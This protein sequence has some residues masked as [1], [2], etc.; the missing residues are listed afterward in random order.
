MGGEY[1]MLKMI[2]VTDPLTE[3]NCYILTEEKHCVVIDPGEAVRTP[4]T[5][6]KSG[7]KPELI[8]LTHEHCDHMGGLAE[9]RHS[10]PE[11][12]FLATERCDCGI[13]SIKLNM[14]GIMGAY[15]YFRGKPGIH[16][17][18]FVCDAADEIIP[19]DAVL[20]WRGHTLRLIPLPGHSPGSSGIMLDEEILFSGDYLLPGEEVILR[21]PGGDEEVYRRETEPV[22]K[23]L[24]KGITICP[25]HGDRYVL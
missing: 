13:R 9:L 11:A 12:R 6:M 20:Q 4:E 22:L 23:R 24:P 25:G 15:L 2:T 7:L 3:S 1:C 18:S 21:F 5:L 10:Y 14:S 8:L 16:Y 19:D 17:D